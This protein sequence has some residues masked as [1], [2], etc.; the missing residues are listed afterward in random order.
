[1]N[2]FRIAVL[3]F[4]ALASSGLPAFAQAAARGGSQ[5][6]GESM[7]NRYGLTRRWWGHAV[8]NSSRDKLMYIIVDENYLFLQSTA[9]VITAFN[10]ETGRQLWARTIGFR[11]RSIFPA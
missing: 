3:C 7:L 10:C 5:L 11:D 9:G 8:V 4:L 2:A 6:P 1:M